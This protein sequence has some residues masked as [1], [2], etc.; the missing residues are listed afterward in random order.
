MPEKI[1]QLIQPVN[2]VE[3]RVIGNSLTKPKDGQEQP[4]QKPNNEL[5]QGESQEKPLKRGST[6][7]I[8]A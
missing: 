7:E 6:F 3:G 8:K 4:E 1:G 5:K 2:H